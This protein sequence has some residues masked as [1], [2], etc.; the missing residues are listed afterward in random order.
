M[1]QHH[2]RWDGQGY[3]QGLAGE[4]ICLEARILAVAD[5]F[6]AMTSQRVYRRALS[7]EEA[8]AE[9][10]RGAGKQFAPECARAFLDLPISELSC[11]LGESLRDRIRIFGRPLREVS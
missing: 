11:C 2:E 6:D 4:E 1:L 3:P 10:E 5:A 7:I 8:L 9:V